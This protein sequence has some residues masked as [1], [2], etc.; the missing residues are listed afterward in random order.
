MKLTISIFFLAA[1]TFSTTAIAKPVRS[2]RCSSAVATTKPDPTPSVEPRMCTK[3]C[4]RSEEDLE[5]GEGWEA[6]DFGGGV[7]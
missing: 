4:A 5:C 2:S 1:L 3:I 6:W 7:S